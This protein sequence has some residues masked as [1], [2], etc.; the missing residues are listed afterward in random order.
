MNISNISHIDPECNAKGLLL[1][2]LGER[3]G[4][5]AT[6]QSREVRCRNVLQLCKTAKGAVKE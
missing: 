5:L 1:T 4:R 2:L 6:A 3:G